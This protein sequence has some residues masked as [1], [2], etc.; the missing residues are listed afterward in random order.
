MGI[1]GAV[2]F[3]WTVSGSVGHKG[4]EKLCLG[5]S[6]S[7][8]ASDAGTILCAAGPSPRHCPSQR[9]AGGHGEEGH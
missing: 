1:G 6:N 5:K 3:S 2:I 8:H 7:H 9:R 4:G